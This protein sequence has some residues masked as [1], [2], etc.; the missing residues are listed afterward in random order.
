M[1]GNGSIIPPID[2]DNFICYPFLASELV[3]ILWMVEKSE[4]PVDRWFSP[5]FIGFQPSKVVQDF[6]H[7]QYVVLGAIHLVKAAEL[8]LGHDFPPLPGFSGVPKHLGSFRLNLLC[9]LCI[10]VCTGTYTVYKYI[11]IYILCIY[12]I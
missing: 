9:I 10:Y 11:H 5:L 8:Q 7:P 12:N 6:F 2:G 3:V 4:S 1:T